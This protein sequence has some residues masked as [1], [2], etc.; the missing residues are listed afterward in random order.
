MSK[1]K[2][3]S[4][5]KKVGDSGAPQGSIL[6]VLIFLISQCDFPENSSD[7][8]ENILYVNNDTDNV[9]DEDPA[10]LE[11][12]LQIQA[13]KSTQWINLLR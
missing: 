13:D 5:P 2:K 10:T 8:V 6:A 11:E 3:R 7:E 9:H 4:T 12:K 1:L